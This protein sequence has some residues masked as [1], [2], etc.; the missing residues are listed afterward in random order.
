MYRCAGGVPHGPVDLAGALEKSCNGYF[1]EL[2][3]RLGPAAVRQMAAA[4][5]FGQGQRVAGS[6]QSASGALPE[7]GTLENQGQFANFCFGQGELMA[8]P[9]QVAAMMNTIAAGGVYRRPLFADC[10]VDETTG[11]ELAP[12]AHW[13]ARRAMSASTAATL[14]ELLA[15]VVARGTGQQAAPAQGTGAGKTGTAQTGQFRQGQELKNY[16]FAGFYPAEKP[17]WTIVVLQD[18]R[19]S[20]G[21]PAPPSLPG[22]AMGWLPGLRGETLRFWLDFWSRLC[23]YILVFVCLLS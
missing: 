9:L 12:L 6:L 2:G 14:R 17:R 23:Y 4:L 21:Y 15:G 13:E 8:T 3:R 19:Q 5:G 7:A 16:W 18:P 20:P 22:C 1:I 11:E 10:V